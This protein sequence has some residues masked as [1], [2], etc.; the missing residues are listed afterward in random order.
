MK[1]IKLIKREIN[2][3][4]GGL[5]VLV[6]LAQLIIGAIFLIP[7]ILGVFFFILAVFD[8]GGSTISLSDLSNNWTGDAMSAAPI[9]LGLMAFA[10]S[11]MVHSAIK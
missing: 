6:T 5:I 9:Y 8:Q 1:K 7:P 10:G 4:A 2:D 11:F 3:D